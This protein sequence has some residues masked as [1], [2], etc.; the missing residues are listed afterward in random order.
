MAH[1]NVSLSPRSR[2]GIASIFARL[3]YATLGKVY[4]DDGGKAFWRAKRG[5]CVRLGSRIASALRSRLVRRGRSLYVGAGVAEIPPLVMETMELDR[6]TEPCN[7]RQAEVTALNRAC[8]PIHLTFR[9]ADAARA[10][11]RFDHLWIV[12]VLNDPERFPNLSDLSYGRAN[13]LAFD[14]VKFDGERRA[15]RR[16]AEQCMGKLS[17]PGLVTTTPEEAPWIAEWCRRQGVPCVV[18][19]RVYATALVGDPICFIHVGA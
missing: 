9:A 17:F 15:V 8:R 10:K 1:R 19:R 7:L 6:E 14:A 18:E 13:P 12:S 2:A 11:G 5:R 16:L 4:C 3:D